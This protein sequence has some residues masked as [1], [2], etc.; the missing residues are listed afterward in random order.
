MTAGN[1]PTKG[2][3]LSNETVLID[4][5]LKS[6]QDARDTPLPDDIAYELLAAQS[7][8]RDYQLSDEEVELGRV[9]GGMDGGIDG[10]Y[11]FLDGTLL[12]EDSDV[13]SQNFKAA[14][15]RRH[16]DI[17][18]WILQ[19]KRE[20]SF[21][22]TTFDK[23]ESSL[24]RLF[25]LTLSD[26]DLTVLYSKELIARV[27]IF[28]ET[29]RTLG[30]RSP[31]ITVHVDYVT[32][33][34]CSTV[35]VPVKTKKRD[36]ESMIAGSI[37][38]SL[39]DVRL[40]GSSELWQILSSEPEYDLQ[41]KVSPYVPLGEAY[42]GLV[43]L[44][45]YYD[46]L[47]D[48]RDEL[49]TNLFDWNVRDYQGEVTVNRAIKD[50]LNS[51]SD[52]DFWW[53]NNGV[54]VLCSEASIGADSTFTLRGVQIVNGMQTSHEIFTALRDTDSS[55]RDKK[56]SVA[57]R[58][59]KTQDED[60]RDRIIRAT[61]SQTKVPDASLHAT[62]AIHRQ[63]E[64]HFKSHGWFYDRRKNF[65]KNTGKPG[66]RI[67]SIGSL[68]Q[69]VTAIGLSRPNDARARPTTLLNNP[70]DYKQIFNTA[71]NLDVYLWLAAAQRKVD[72]MLTK[73]VDAYIKTNLRFYV[74]CYLVTRQ[75]GFRIYNP[76]Q[77]REIAEIP[78][79]VDSTT[80]FHSAQRIEEIAVNLADDEEPDW[81]LDRI[82]KNRGFAEAVI[83]A[84]LD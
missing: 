23:L 18:V 76:K 56:R 50:T 7:V 66:D 22:E 4:Q 53:F 37:K 19:A 47:S 65:Y 43:R 49:R 40:I 24:R 75:A 60:I 72:A 10:F 48:G 58:I 78:F 59:I 57:V 70:S 16:A 42:S 67:I 36:L 20:T 30:I 31:R 3:P 9:G 5:Y 55:D 1:P 74:S 51:S 77:L 71:V 32:K 82:A 38:G 81:S 45:D 34:D 54:T 27:R 52:E 12:D 29:W 14:D 28:T 17:D 73:E 21:S 46:F 68:G 6:R 69:A 64:A 79:E 13:L 44:A 25:D 8:L 83:E 80:I 63:I 15:I 62:E 39:V 11:T 41:L 2:S 61:N 84:A 33:G 26:S 35:G